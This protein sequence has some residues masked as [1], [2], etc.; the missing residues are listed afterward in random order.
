MN[1]IFIDKKTEILKYIKGKH[2]NVDILKV[3]V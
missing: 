1:S 2:Q 3:D